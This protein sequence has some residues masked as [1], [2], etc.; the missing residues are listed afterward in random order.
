MF[1]NYLSTAWRNIVKNSMF[2]AINIFGLAIGLMSCILI[3]LY[4]REETGFD[5]WLSKSDRLVRLHTAYT[6]PDNPPFYTVRSAGRMMSALLDYA[7]SEIEEG[8]RLLPFNMTVRKDGDAVEEQ[9]TIVDGSFF[10]IFDLPFL[11]GSAERSFAKPYDLV[12][13]EQM[14]RKYFG[15]TDVVDETITVCC[16][17]DDTITFS[18]TGVVRDLPRATHLDLDFIIYLHPALI[19]RFPGVF[20]TWTSVNVYT[21]FKMNE[22]ITVAQLQDRIDYWLENESPFLKM[23]SKNMALS[24]EA[25]TTDSVNHRVM[26]VTDLHLN[27]K[28]HAGSMGDLTP[29]GD[30]RMIDTFII[31]AFLIL[32]IA[33]INFMNLATAKASQRSREVAM[34]KV[35]GAKRSQIIV[36]FL[37]E[38][39][40]L[41]LIAL[42]FALVAVELVLPFFNNALGR[43]LEF[44]LFDDLPML[45]SLLAV[46]GLVGVGAG[47]YPAL[48]LSRFLPAH[49]LKSNKSS[50]S[51][52]AANIRTALV[53]F[54][55]AVSIVLLVS[56]AMIFSQTMYANSIDVGYSSDDKLVLNIRPARK[57]LRSLKQALLNL[58]EISSVVYSSEVPTQDNENNTFFK[59]LENQSIGTADR[60]QTLNHHTMGYGF[61]EAYDVKPVAGRLFDEAF[62]S[63]IINPIPEGEDATANAS[64]IL[65]MSAVK[66]FGFADAQQAL[67]RTLETTGPRDQRQH[68]TIVGV[69]PDIY[70]RSIKFGVRPSVYLLN[71]SRFNVASL[72]FS[73]ENLPDLIEKIETIWKNNVPMQPIDLNFLSE[74]MTAQYESEVIQTKLFSIFSMLAIL[75]ACMGLYGL[76]AFSA[77]RRTREIGLRKVMGARVW[78]IVLLMVWQFSLP[79]IMANLIA[80][81][82]AIYVMSRWLETFPYRVD[83]IWLLPMCLAAGGVSLI[84]AWLTVGSNAANVARSNPVNTLRCE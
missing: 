17:D 73:S 9:F 84:I 23:F 61:F 10:T 36:Q 65:N 31:V 67:G 27:A 29:M 71:P 78:D 83:A 39:V 13:T 57:S 68:L 24:S 14:A 41:V 70:F 77:Y 62:G 40:G 54:Q 80:W 59:L 53:V 21:Y 38:A 43:E 49:I 15:R 18:I 45:F 74:M 55:F 58:P 30:K 35:L 11:H 50:D 12:I 66:K 26:L 56:T 37:G 7:K 81:P 6:A 60:T 51:S 46:A 72:T 5:Q 52:G 48:Y 64:V 1:K 20:K 25:K 75:V 2:S 63:D 47:L 82:L 32:L 22:G 34:R 69:I 19:D 3:M 16:V 44:R 8:V 33:C 28:S 4:V 76:A 79:V 42:L